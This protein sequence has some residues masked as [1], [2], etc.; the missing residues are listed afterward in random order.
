M[1]EMQKKAV[2]ALSNRY[3]GYEGNRVNKPY[4]GVGDHF[5]DFNGQDSFL[6]VMQSL[7]QFTFQI[8]HTASSGSPATKRVAIHP[9]YYNRAYPNITQ[10]NS[11]KNITI[12]APGVVFTDITNIN[13]AG[14]AVD[15]VMT[16]GNILTYG[17]NGTLVVSSLSGVNVE[18]FLNFSKLAPLCVPHITLECDNVAGY[19]SVMYLRELQPFRKFVETPIRLQNYFDTKQFQTG[20]IEIDLPQLQLDGQTVLTL[21][22]PA[23]RTFTITYW[24]GAILNPSFALDTKKNQANSTIV[25][26]LAAKK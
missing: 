9:G 20:K 1:N 2:A 15:A 5:V 8:V 10:D 26:A 23:G 13:A 16:D 6:S 25:Q 14:H 18:D 21:D 3:E 11:T 7:R 4:L 22:I 12:G 24:V 17:S 19:S